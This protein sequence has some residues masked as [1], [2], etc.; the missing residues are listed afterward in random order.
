MNEMFSFS[1][2]N[3]LEQG[4]GVLSEITSGLGKNSATAKTLD[5]QGREIAV[6]FM[7]VRPNLIHSLFIT[8]NYI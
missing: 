6:E 7:T 1:S 4:A 8:L 2:L 3:Q 5:L